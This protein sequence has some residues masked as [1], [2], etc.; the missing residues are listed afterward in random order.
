MEARWKPPFEIAAGG[1]PIEGRPSLAVLYPCRGSQM[2]R[3][4]QIREF[5][6]PGL[7]RHPRPVWRRARMPVVK[8]DV[9]RPRGWVEAAPWRGDQCFKSTQNRPDEARISGV[10]RPCAECRIRWKGAVWG[11]R[12]PRRLECWFSKHE[13]AFRGLCPVPVLGSGDPGQGLVWENAHSRS[14]MSRISAG[15]RS[16]SLTALSRRCT[17]FATRSP[18]VRCSLAK[19]STTSRSCSDTETLTSRAPSTCVSYPTRAVVRCADPE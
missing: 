17:A 7:E 13:T 6:W 4:L 18:A 8:S 9:P 11:D 3:N 2:R 1:S 14:Y 10:G 19:A 12:H 5:E 16:W 15:I